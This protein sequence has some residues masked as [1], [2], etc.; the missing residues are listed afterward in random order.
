MPLAE[1]GMLQ[2]DTMRSVYTLAAVGAEVIVIAQLMNLHRERLLTISGGV[3]EVIPTV[4][5]EPEDFNFEEN[6]NGEA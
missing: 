4:E 5:V 3:P 1:L 2:A 6:L